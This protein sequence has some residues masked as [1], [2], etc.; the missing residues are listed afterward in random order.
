MY[1][2]LQPVMERVLGVRHRDALEAYANLAYWT[3]M[4]GQ[5]NASPESEDSEP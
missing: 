1:A 4:A 5:G 3:E 2:A